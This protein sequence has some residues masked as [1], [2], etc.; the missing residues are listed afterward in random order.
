M[1]AWILETINNDGIVEWF[2]FDRVRK[3]TIYF[4]LVGLEQKK[5]IDSDQ[6]VVTTIGLPIVSRSFENQSNKYISTKYDKYTIKITSTTT[7][8]TTS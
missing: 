2:S 5:T 6:S 1:V 3:T 7:T 8:T 4:V